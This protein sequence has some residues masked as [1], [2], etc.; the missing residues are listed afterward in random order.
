MMRELKAKP[1]NE[2]EV[3]IENPNESP[4]FN[5]FLKYLRTLS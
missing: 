2:V 5:G 3:H 4:N 1:K